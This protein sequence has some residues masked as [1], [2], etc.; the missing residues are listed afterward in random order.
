[1]KASQ[2]PLHFARLADVVQLVERFE[3]RT[4]PRD[5]WSHRAHLTVT[6]WYMAHFDDIEASSRMIDG[7]RAYH[8]AR[9]IRQ[10]P[11]GGYHE[12][13]T[14]FWLALARR[15]LK[16]F[17]RDEPD[18]GMFNEFLDHPGSRSDR[19]Y[20]HYTRARLF[21]SRARQAWVEPDL[22]PLAAEPA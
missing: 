22:R 21:S 11:A 5:Q 18:V 3:D 13:I 16:R 20:E 15:F 4:L 2:A 7:I 6:L 8:H 19:I 1:M 12:T 17:P 10:T 9:G 14:L